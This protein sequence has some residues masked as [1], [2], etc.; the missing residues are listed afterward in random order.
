MR[1][2]V[3]IIIAAY[4][5]VISLISA[6]ITVFDKIRSKKRGARRV[7]EST[8][9]TLSALGGA[10]AMFLTMLTIRHKTKHAKFMIG[11]PAIMLA[12]ALLIAAVVYITDFRIWDFFMV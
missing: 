3:L 2:T 6:V 9:L 10:L 7:P 8:L 5:A 11:I 1:D 12:E 4:F